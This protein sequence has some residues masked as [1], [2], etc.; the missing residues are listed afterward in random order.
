ML[1]YAFQVL[2]N[3]GYAN[4]SFEDFDHVQDLLSAIL[5][6]GISNQIKRGISK[7]Y[8]INSDALNSPKSKLLISH[9]IKTNAIYRKQICC[10]YDDFSENI[11]LNQILKS[12]AYSLLHSD[13]V[14][15]DRKK[16]LKKVLVF[17][18]SVSLITLSEIKWNGI[19]YQ[20]NNATYKMLI[21]ICYLVAQDLIFEENKNGKKFKKPVDD[22][23]MHR[24]YEKFILEY[25]RKHYP[26]LSPQASFISWDTDDGMVTLL[27]TMKSDITLSY[28]DKVLIIDAKYYTHMLQHNSLYD[29]KTIHSNNLY[30]IFTYVKNKDIIHN[31]NVSGLLLYAKTDEDIVPNNKYKMS[32]NDILVQTL[33]LNQPFKEISKQ[34]DS[35]VDI[36]L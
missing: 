15:Q 17:F 20:K 31:G 9:T 22:Q 13:K 36:W 5:T 32:G 34:L 7:D 19:Y 1:A 30:Q 25:Y 11:Y 14:K 21:N 16:A 27:P 12:T 35:I 33:D 8:I 24:L 26:E 23:S 28:R 3:D 29:K 6:K 10:E 2:K 4:L 18:Q